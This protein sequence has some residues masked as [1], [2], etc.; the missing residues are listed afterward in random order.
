MTS[1]TWAVGICLAAIAGTIAYITYMA[2]VAKSSEQFAD[3]WVMPGRLTQE[4][5]PVLINALAPEP[6][7]CFVNKVM[8]PPQYEPASGHLKDSTSNP[9]CTIDAAY[10][11]IRDACAPSTASSLF[12]SQVVDDIS[13]MPSKR[14]RLYCSIQFKPTATSGQLLAYS[15]RNDPDYKIRQLEATGNTLGSDMSSLQDKVKA[16]EKINE[17][18]AKGIEQLTKDRAQLQ[19]DNSSQIAQLQMDYSNLQAKLIKDLA[20]ASADCVAQVSKANLECTAK[21]SEIMMTYAWP[22]V[23]MTDTSLKV[24][25]RSYGNGTYT[26]SESTWISAERGFWLFDQSS[27]SGWWTG[28]GS[29]PGGLYSGTAAATSLSDGTVYYGDWVQLAFPSGV[30]LREARM[31]IRAGFTGRYPSAFIIAGSNDGATF[32]RLYQI[33]GVPAATWNAGPVICSF[34]NN[35]TAYRMYRVS[36][37]R[38]NGDNASLSMVTFYSNVR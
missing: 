34:P 25:G 37:N 7:P 12:D 21:S 27:T 5:G 24:T 28:A 11:G 16:L 18:Q 9:T 3:S 31:Q 1:H 30:E 35:T 6:E 22:P 19:S 14:G 36:V 15:Q 17:M 13:I 32:T 10:P 33:S 26:A 8:M 23:P 29:Y 2:Y 4:I 38:T 20:T